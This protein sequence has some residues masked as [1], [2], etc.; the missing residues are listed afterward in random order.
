MPYCSTPD[1]D[2]LVHNVNASSG[3][4]GLA[5][6]AAPAGGQQQPGAATSAQQFTRADPAASVDLGN[7][8]GHSLN[9]TEQWE[10]I[11]RP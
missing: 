1:L 9:D 11:A 6:A 4:G 3:Q 2:E 8:V 5:P 7:S 10:P